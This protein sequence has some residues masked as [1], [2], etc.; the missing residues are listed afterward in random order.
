MSKCPKCNKEISPFYMKENCPYCNVNLLYYNLEQR[1][2]ADEAQ[3]NREYDAMERF[4]DLLK[5]SSV[6]SP[7]LII[8]LV[9]F[10]IPLGTL[11]LP[12]YGDLSLI[13]IIT[14][15][16]SGSL[17]AGEVILQLVSIA[18]V[19]VM[20]LAVIIASLFSAGKHGF[21][22]NMILSAVNAAAFAALGLAA[23]DVK[24]GWFLTLA[25]LISE[26]LLHIACKKSIDKKL[27]VD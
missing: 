15:L 1:L 11:C 4:F 24:I 16:I 8:R 21:Y 27:N 22:R 17:A 14:G 13:T 5:L 18:L 25:V 23:G 3:A 20:S 10:F 9:V 12:V 19:V 7:L 26:L 6:S 2:E